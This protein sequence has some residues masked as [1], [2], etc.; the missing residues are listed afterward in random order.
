M[1]QQLCLSLS[2]VRPFG[3]PTAYGGTGGRYDKDGLKQLLRARGISPMTRERLKSEMFPAKQRKSAALKF[4]AQRGRELLA[5][6][7]R[8]GPA[9][10]RNPRHFDTSE[11]GRSTAIQHQTV[12]VWH[13]Q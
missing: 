12:P 6:T 9:N 7:D 5:F 1:A 10:P 13:F 8:L 4:R 2:G 3:V 11:D